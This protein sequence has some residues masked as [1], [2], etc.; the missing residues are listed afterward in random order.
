MIQPA[1]RK[2][3]STRKKSIFRFFLHPFFVDVFIGLAVF[4]LI[5]GLVLTAIS[6]ERYELQAGDIPSEPIAAPR[7]VEDV[8]ATQE[9]VKQARQQVSDIYI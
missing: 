6:P 9:K 5:F 1:V 8:M 3:K 7:D 2:N 4:G